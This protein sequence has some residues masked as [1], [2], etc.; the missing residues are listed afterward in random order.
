GDF[1]RRGQT[2][3]VILAI[4]I[5]VAFEAAALGF[6]NLAAK[7]PPTTPLIYLNALAPIVGGLYLLVTDLRRRPRTVE[8]DMW[9]A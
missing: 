8:A 5:I 2:R 4:L 7:Y 9:S 6:Q 3:R 1:S